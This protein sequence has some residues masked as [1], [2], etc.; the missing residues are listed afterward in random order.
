[1]GEVN[2]LIDK[3][4]GKTYEDV[5]GILPPPFFAYD[6]EFKSSDNDEFS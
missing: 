2:Y 3:V 6:M 1:M 5:L 4:E